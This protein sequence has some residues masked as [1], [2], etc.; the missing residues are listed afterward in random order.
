MQRG[1]NSVMLSEKNLWD[2]AI[3]HP[4]YDEET[5]KLMQM[6]ASSNGS[7]TEFVFNV[8]CNAVPYFEIVDYSGEIQDPFE[9]YIEEVMSRDIV[10]HSSDTIRLLTNEYVI[11][12]ESVSSFLQLPQ[13]EFQTVEKLTRF[14][15]RYLTNV[16]HVSLPQTFHPE[17][18]LVCFI[19][20]Y[21]FV[22]T[23]SLV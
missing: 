20:L 7:L 2:L 10:I 6:I 19:L 23:V 13:L 8:F 17:E 9:P 14:L 12:I 3:Q 21:G 11:D 1:L 18:T 15:D 16:L 5:H 4:M 22:M